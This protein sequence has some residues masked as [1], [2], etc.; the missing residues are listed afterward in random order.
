MGESKR[1][2]LPTD[3]FDNGVVDAQMTQKFVQ[4]TGFCGWAESAILDP[5]EI[6]GTRPEE[7]ARS[8]SAEH[9]NVLMHSLNRR[10]LP[11]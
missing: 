6:S 2:F 1:L 10:F 8:V 5:A 3:D 7:V 9:E 11:T 4:G